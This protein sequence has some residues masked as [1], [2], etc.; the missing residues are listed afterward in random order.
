MLQ[1]N[2]EV[3]GRFKHP[4]GTTI[5]IRT[6]NVD[7]GVFVYATYEKGV[8]YWNLFGFI[9]GTEHINNLIKSGFDL[10]KD[11][12]DIQINICHAGAQKIMKY[13]CKMGHVV[14]AYYDGIR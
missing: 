8:K 3:I 4:Q 6:G 14:T 11:C 13:A 1:F 5:E 10:F 2:N 12:T 7:G 9:D